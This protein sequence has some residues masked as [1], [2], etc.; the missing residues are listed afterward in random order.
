MNAQQIFLAAFSTN[1]SKRSEAYKK[2]VLTHL[3][4]RMNESESFN[5]PFA[6]G[7]AEFD[8]FYAGVEESWR[9]LVVKNCDKRGHV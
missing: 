1:R 8:A 6:E 5:C 3:R 9:L 7:A 2:G 4:Y